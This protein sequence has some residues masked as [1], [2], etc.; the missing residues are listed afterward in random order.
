[1]RQREYAKTAALAV[2]LIVVLVQV[3]RSCGVLPGG[4]WVSGLAVGAPWWA[5]LLHPFIHVG[6]GHAL[7]NVYVLWQLVFFFPVRL[8]HLFFAYL[9]ACSCPAGWAG[10][11]VIH[12]SAGIPVV[13]LSGVI[14]VLMGWAMTKVNRKVRFNAVVMGW[15]AFATAVGGVAVGLHLYGY[16]VGALTAMLVC[17]R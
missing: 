11:T 16:V 13:G 2:G 1:M 14:Y 8:R 3:L 4:M 15:M 7:I 10:W 17:R 9:V 12:L 5:R 6:M